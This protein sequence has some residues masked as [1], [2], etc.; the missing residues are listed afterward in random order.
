[1]VDDFFIGITWFDLESWAG[2]RI[3]SRGRSYQRSGRVKKLA[4]TESGDL[5]AWV[6]G[7]RRYATMVEINGREIISSCT[8]PY[9]VDC[10]HA[11]AVVFEYLEF[12][13]NEKTV[14]S[15]NDKDKRLELLRRDMEAHSNNV[16]GDE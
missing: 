12:L 7:S 11:V 1:M 9:G 16:F 3:V 13:K 10:K 8:C 4:R 5:V 2:P 15:A 14:P 6:D